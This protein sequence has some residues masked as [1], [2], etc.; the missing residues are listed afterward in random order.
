MSKLLENFNTLIKHNIKM[1]NY[2]AMKCLDKCLIE[3][4][5][6]CQF[7]VRLGIY[8]QI[9]NGEITFEEAVEIVINENNER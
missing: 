2:Q 3:K 6:H 5:N 4:V 8:Q 7:P 1:N 9:I